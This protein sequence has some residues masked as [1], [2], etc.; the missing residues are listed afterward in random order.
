MILAHA[1]M[2]TSVLVLGGV[3]VLPCISGRDE[4]AWDGSE[5]QAKVFRMQRGVEDGRTTSP[6]TGAT[7]ARWGDARGGKAQARLAAG[8]ARRGARV[9]LVSSYARD[10]DHSGPGRSARCRK[11]GLRIPVGGR[12]HHG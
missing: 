6:S 12:R 11:A 3:A 1:R 4:P 7:L 10:V 9:T 5:S 8:S 2:A